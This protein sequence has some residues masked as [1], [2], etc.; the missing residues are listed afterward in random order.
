M[1]KWATWKINKSYG[2]LGL[3]AEKQIFHEKH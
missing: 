1:L 2:S 3:F